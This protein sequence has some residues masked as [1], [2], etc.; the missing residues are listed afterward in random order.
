MNLNHKH[1]NLLFEVA[2]C[3]SAKV[4]HLMYGTDCK[5]YSKVAD[6]TQEAARFI[7][8]C[9]DRAGSWAIFSKLLLVLSHKE[10]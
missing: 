1:L 8:I 9:D 2:G 7:R 5:R 10:Y 6:A 4:S 3:G